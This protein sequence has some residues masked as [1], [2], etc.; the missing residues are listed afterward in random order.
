MSLPKKVLV[1]F[2]VWSILITSSQAATRSVKIDFFTT[3]VE[4][5]FD[6][7][8][9]EKNKHCT[10]T[11]CLKRFYR[12]LDETNF[13]VLLD[14]LKDRK[15]ELQLNDWLFYQ[16]IHKA[17]DKLY[18]NESSMFR[19]T[20]TWFFM[21]KAGYNT[22]LLTSQSKYT[23]L[24]VQTEEKIFETSFVRFGKLRFVNL[25]NIYYNVDSRKIIFEIPRYQPG[26]LRDKPFSFAMKETPLIPAQ[27]IKKVYDFDVNGEPIALEVEVDTNVTDLLKNFPQTLPLN[28][29]QA[30]MSPATMTSLKNALAP[31][32]NGKTPAEQ[33]SVMVSFTRK[34]FPYLHDQRRYLRDDP[35]TADQLMLA[36]TSDHEDRVALLYQLLK[37][38]TDFNFILVQY[39]HDDIITV[40]VELPEVIGR[41]FE[42]EGKTYTICDPTLPKNSSKLGNYPISLDKD[43]EILEVVNQRE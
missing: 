5:K 27:T 31:H 29:I 12:K 32:L 3:K 7:S 28:H 2:S 18:A 26:E 35:L 4:L 33:L 13:Q 22:R 21:T 40:G 9:L 10:S 17:V 24:C 25:T 15:D 8:I 20:A 38:T 30:P 16:L 41:P 37:E 11:P 6:D 19:T 39:I 1:L 14:D 34:A 23:F 36:D 42:H 43:I